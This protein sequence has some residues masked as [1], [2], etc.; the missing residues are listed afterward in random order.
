MS[1]SNTLYV[2]GLNEKVKKEELRRSLYFLFSQHGRIISIV[3]MKTIKAR[4]QAFICFENVNEASSAM[5][6]LQG[7]PLYDK[8]IKI[9]YARSES[10]AMKLLKGTYF[11]SKDSEKRPRDQDDEPRKK[12][13]L[14]SEESNILQASGL[15]SSTTKEQL[16]SLFQQY[17]GFQQIKMVPGQLVAF[18]EFDTI[19]HSLAA[20]DALHGF[21]IDPTHVLKLEYRKT[22]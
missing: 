13:K 11:T 14:E 9:Q 19:Q 22:E 6:I 18:I 8:K 10:N 17:E 3:A 1:Q 7:F 21:K 5:R 2:N 20:K 4:G 15:P 16:D 12:Q